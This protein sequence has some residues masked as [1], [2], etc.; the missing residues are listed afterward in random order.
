MITSQAVASCVYR[1]Q[2]QH[3]TKRL[4]DSAATSGRGGYGLAMKNKTAEKRSA[5]PDA[6]CGRRR[7]ERGTSHG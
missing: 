2:F 6:A 3:K 1:P 4:T 7:P 5:A